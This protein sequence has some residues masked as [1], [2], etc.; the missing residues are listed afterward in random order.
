MISLP[1][2]RA[3][4]ELRTPCFTASSAEC[5]MTGGAREGHFR[6]VY[7]CHPRRTT[8]HRPPNDDVCCKKLTTFPRPT[9]CGCKTSEYKIC[10]VVSST[11]RSGM[12]TQHGLLNCACPGRIAR[13]GQIKSA[14]LCSQ[15][16]TPSLPEF[17]AR[18]PYNRPSFMST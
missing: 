8:Q 7:S 13:L 18:V 6:Y 1:H 14:L 15:M 10:Y 12:Q 16:I 17:S 4:I 2:F 11:E 3:A 9:R 5:K